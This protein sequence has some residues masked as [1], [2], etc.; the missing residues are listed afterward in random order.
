MLAIVLI[1]AVQHAEPERVSHG[2]TT[3]GDE[4]RRGT[5]VGLFVVL[6]VAF[7]VSFCGKRVPE[8]ANVVSGTPHISWIIMVGDSDNADRDFVCQSTGPAD[9][10]VP[11][12]DPEAPVFSDVH[13]YYHGAGAQ[14]KYSGSVLIG[15]FTGPSES[16]TI[17]VDTTVRKNEEIANQSVTGIVAD[18]PGT[19]AITFDLTATSQAGNPQPVHDEVRVVVK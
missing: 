19:Y 11:A 15:F 9:C 12:S 2:V 13:V 18:K 14:T 16:K 1:V 5:T 4:M 17:P 3:R 7:V 8:P 6:A 10:V